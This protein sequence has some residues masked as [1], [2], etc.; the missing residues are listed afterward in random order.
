MSW[1]GAIF[2]LVVTGVLGTLCYF[3]GRHCGERDQQRIAHAE[4]LYFS[5]TCIVVNELTL[6]QRQALWESGWRDKPKVTES[7]IQ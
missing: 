2:L 7:S 1:I 5:D 3:Y 4:R 6:G